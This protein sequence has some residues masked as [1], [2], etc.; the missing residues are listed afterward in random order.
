MALVLKDRVQET[1][2][3]N[4]TVSFT[5]AGA[6]T[7]FQ[8]FST[9]GNTNTTYYSATDASGNWEVG[10]GTYST[11][12]P[13]LTR[14]T[15]LSSSNAGSAV[16]FSGT[17]NVFATYPAGKSINYD[18][19][20]VA[21]LGSTLSYSDTGVIGSFASTVANYNQVILQNLSS[22]AAASANFNISNDSGTATTNYG[23]FGINS[24]TFTGS[25][26]FNTAG[27]VYLAAASTDLAVGTYGANAIHFLVNS[28][29]TDA[30]S[31]SSAGRWA[32][33]AAGTNT[34][35]TALLHLGAGTATASTAP[36]KLTSGTNLTTAEAGAVE[37]DGTALYMTSF[38][39]SRG[40]VPTTQIQVLSATYTL[41]SQTAA[42]KLLNATTNGAVTLAVGV[43]EFECQFMLTNMSATSGTLGFAL[44]GTATITQQWMAHASR[45]GTTATT[46]TSGSTNAVYQ[47]N[48]TAANTAITA[49]ST[50]TTGS[51]L[52][53]GFI[54]VTVAGTVIPQVSMS[55]ASAAVVQTGAYFKITPISATSTTTFVGNW[56]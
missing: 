23:E 17:V 22:N 27:S 6:V 35:S 44:G 49:A 42:Q 47:T 8:S 18:A 5:M 51:A 13:T 3:A 36:L 38:G 48:N 19:N 1:G 24:S 26:S 52:I 11:T 46:I 10:L 21:T 14:T 39:T 9:I 20:G 25:G 34:T 12:G 4:T 16:T 32:I 31:I 54:R 29:A 2:T 50:N 37:Y 56:T 41:T 43:Y 28:G 53:K 55:V 30:G 40:Y 33:N 15:I 45:S 7:G